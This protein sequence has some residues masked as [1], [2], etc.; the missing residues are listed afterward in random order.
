MII[1]QNEIAANGLQS[2]Y[3]L[4]YKEINGKQ[5]GINKINWSNYETRHTW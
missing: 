2:S 3:Q 4:P 1:I 5:Q